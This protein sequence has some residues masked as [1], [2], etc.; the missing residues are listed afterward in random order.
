MY[1]VCL[2]EICQQLDG[3]CENKFF[4]FAM[5]ECE[6]IVLDF[7]QIYRKSLRFNFR[8]D[9]ISSSYVILIFFAH[10]S[11]EDIITFQSFLSW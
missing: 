8:G 11:L 10:M 9:G 4:F 3:E 1:V 6:N 2:P 7:P 5:R